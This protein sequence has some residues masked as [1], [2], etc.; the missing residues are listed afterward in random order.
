MSTREERVL[1][2][3]GT[4]I[5]STLG[6]VVAETNKIKRFVRAKRR[7]VAKKVR[8]AESRAAQGR[9]AAAAAGRRL[10]AKVRGVGEIAKRNLRKATGRSKR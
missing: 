7:A 2:D 9:K 8:R 4:A 10:R 3:V 6:A 1:A 5:G